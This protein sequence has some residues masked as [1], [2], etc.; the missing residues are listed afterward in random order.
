MTRRPAEFRLREA[1]ADDGAAIRAV[2][3]AVMNEYGLSS[4]LEGN[5]ADLHDVVASY[6][7]RGGSFR[8]VTTVEG[9]VVGC[10]GLYPIDDRE[11][12]IRRMYL[13]PEA[14]GVGI[15]R[16]LLEELISVAMERRFE[17]VILETAAVLKQAISLYRQRG[18][19]PV[20]RRGSALRQCDQ[21]YALQVGNPA[22]R[23]GP[24]S[25]PG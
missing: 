13:L 24:H 1:A 17:R 18:F 16:R 22:Q 25:G 2:V 8:V 20:A 23:S 12:E 11:A 10:G 15:G 3:V 21:A 14:R 9:V 19:E 4:D 7:D 6:R 5:D